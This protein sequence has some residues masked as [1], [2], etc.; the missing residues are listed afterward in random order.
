MMPLDESTR[1]A[2]IRD[3][4]TPGGYP[5]QDGQP[6]LTVYLSDTSFLWRGGH[7]I[8]VAPEGYGEPVQDIIFTENLDTYSARAAMNKL[9]SEAEQWVSD[10]R[11]EDDY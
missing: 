5:G 9:L 8:Y 1:R 7:C 11:D 4:R 2:L 10:H 6:H 3:A